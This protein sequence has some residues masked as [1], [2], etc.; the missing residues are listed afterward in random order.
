MDNKTKSS[1]V[2]RIKKLGRE[3]G[4]KMS[5]VAQKAHVSR[6]TIYF[7]GKGREP[8]PANLAKVAAVLGVS[9]KELIEEGAGQIVPMAAHQTKMVCPYEEEVPKGWQLVP[10]LAIDFAAG[11]GTEPLVED[12]SLE[13]TLL[14]DAF[15]IKH[16]TVP[17]RVK[18]VSVTG[19]SMEP[20]VHDKDEVIYEQELTPE[21]PHIRDGQIY[22]LW[23]GS[24]LRIKRLSMK[25]DGSLVVR[26]DNPVYQTEEIPQSQLDRV[27]VYGR[28][29]RVLHDV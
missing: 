9:P 5:D 13:P 12:N 22:L 25:T 3:K 19:D 11:D 16:Q 21:S 4:W 6:Q 1:L 17:E 15:Y 26:S 18:I 20:T 2:D 29:L 7:W 28:V 27:R 8:D 24:G 14:P 23:D 10:R